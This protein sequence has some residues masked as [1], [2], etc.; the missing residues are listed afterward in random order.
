[1]KS[2]IGRYLT[3]GLG[4]VGLYVGGVWFGTEVLDLS[5]RPTNAF[6]YFLAT[7]ISFGLNYIWV[8]ASKAR[9]G[10]ALT[11]FILL[12]AVGVGLNV[13]WVEAGLH[14]TSLYPWVIAAA[15]FAA[16]PFLS[17]SMQKRYIFNR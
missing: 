16:W 14:F 5:V 10:N 15:Y 2:R 9:P 8:F 4:T 17:F 6:F 1:M 7:L 12:Q 13:I 11:L 3:A